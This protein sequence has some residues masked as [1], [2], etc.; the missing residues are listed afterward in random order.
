MAREAVL[1]MTDLNHTGTL[2]L[3]PG[4]RAAP[5]PWV[6]RGDVAQVE[7]VIQEKRAAIAV[8]LAELHAE[9][10]NLSMTDMRLKN[11]LSALL[12]ASTEEET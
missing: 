2:T 5:E 7:A 1:P 4:V 8:R 6:K 11:S 10:F 9:M 12:G 3:P